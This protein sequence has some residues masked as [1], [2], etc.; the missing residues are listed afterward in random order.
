MAGAAENYQALLRRARID[1]DIAEDPQ[2]F[3]AAADAWTNCIVRYLVGVRHRRRLASDLIVALSK[4]TMDPAHSVK[5]VPA[6][7]RSEIRLR[8]TWAPLDV[9]QPERLQD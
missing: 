4:A 1:F 9:T 8:R 2:V 7:P 6:Y 5:I 3:L